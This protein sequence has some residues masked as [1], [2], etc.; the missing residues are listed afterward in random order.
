MTPRYPI[1]TLERRAPRVVYEFNAPDLAIAACMVK[2]GNADDVSHE[3]LDDEPTV[4]EIISAERIDGNDLP[5][6]RPHQELKRMG[7]DLSQRELIGS[8][9]SSSSSSGGTET[10]R[11]GTATCHCRSTRSTSSPTCSTELACARPGSLTTTLNPRTSQCRPAL[12]SPSGPLMSP[13]RGRGGR[14]RPERR[15]CVGVVGP[16]RATPHGV[17][18]TPPVAPP[19]IIRAPCAVREKF[20]EAPAA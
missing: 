16:T 2:D 8:S 15:T 1:E 13:H 3:T 19:G 6:P 20:D 5:A 7:S 11:F 9:T 17:C 18:K 12:V 10:P 4:A 14:S